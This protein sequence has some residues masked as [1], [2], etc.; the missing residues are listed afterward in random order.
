MGIG[1]KLLLAGLSGFLVMIVWINFVHVDSVMGAVALYGFSGSLFMAGVLLPYLKHQDLISWRSTALV[2]ISGASF[3]CAVFAANKWS[4]MWGPSTL[5]YVIASLS[6]AAIVLL[7]SPFVL[8]LRFSVK[9]AVVGI[10]SA[11]VGGI[12]FDVFDD[13]FG[14]SLFLSFG[15]WHMLMCIS[16]HSGNPSAAE[17]GWLASV[18]KAK[19]KIFVA[20]L[21]LFVIVP[22]VDDGIGALVQ[23][24]YTAHEGGIRVHDQIEARGFRDERQK[25]MFD[26]SDCGFGCISRVAD[27]TYA[28]Q[29]YDVDDANGRYQL[30]FIIDRPDPNCYTSFEDWNPPFKPNFDEFP[31]RY[32][33]RCLTY[34]LKDEPTAE[35]VIRDRAETVH[36]GFGL[37]SL[38]KTNRQIVRLSDDEVVTEA[39]YFVYHSRFY[40]DSFGDVAPWDEF[41]K[42]ALPPGSGK[43]QPPN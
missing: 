32:E 27:E 43:W 4:G 24:R 37:Y 28:F 13:L 17:A 41:L 26:W 8:N 31:R 29:E 1:L 19:L 11:L 30:F 12:A 40:G 6:G 23:Y 18:G 34:R 9:Y 39:T 36:A 20:F 15:S 14:Y 35:Y 5:D 16:L 21:S 10:L 7:A 22:L 3:Y 42:Q 25:P 38:R 33:D 2:L